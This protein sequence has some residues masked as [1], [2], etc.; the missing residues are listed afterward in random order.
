MGKPFKLFLVIAPLWLILDV[1]LLFIIFTNL[2]DF[3]RVIGYSG[4]IYYS[5]LVFS[6]IFTVILAPESL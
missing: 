4:T 2:T 1:V 3:I 5:I 6:Y